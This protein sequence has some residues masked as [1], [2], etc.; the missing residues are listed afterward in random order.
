[1][2]ALISIAFILGIIAVMVLL[3]WGICQ[4]LVW[5]A[6]RVEQ[7]RKTAHPHLWELF[8]EVSSKSKEA[9]QQY[10]RNVAPLKKQIKYILDR[11]PYWPAEIR[12]AKEEE[13]E[14]LR[15]RLYGAELSYNILEAELEEIRK[16]IREYVSDNDL[17][18]ARN[19]G[20]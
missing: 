11:L 13:A 3:T 8:D 15:L 9:T 12:E 10:N 19:W 6:N 17:E 4:I 18:W 16:E 14:N 1:M 20:W 5:N 2:A 7:K